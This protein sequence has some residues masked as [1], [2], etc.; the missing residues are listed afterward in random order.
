MSNNAACGLLGGGRG[1]AAK[2]GRPY[3]AQSRAG[4][5][6]K[7]SDGRLICFA[8]NNAYERCPGGCGKAHVCQRCEGNHPA[9]A[10]KVVIN[11]DGG[12]GGGAAPASKKKEE[13]K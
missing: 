13:Q 5:R 12:G 11:V 1:A 7:T 8:F 2:G 9:H 10:C 4:W 3:V 6:S